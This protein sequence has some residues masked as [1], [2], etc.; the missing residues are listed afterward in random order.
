MPEQMTPMTTPAVMQLAESILTALQSSGLPPD[1]AIRAL[2]LCM[3]EVI[4]RQLGHNTPPAAIADRVTAITE[5]W[6]AMLSSAVRIEA[7]LN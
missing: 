4:A 3:S 5:T 7:T 6:T 2:L 1:E